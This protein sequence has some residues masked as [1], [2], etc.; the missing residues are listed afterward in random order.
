MTPV[1]KP[2]ERPGRSVETEPHQGA[3]LYCKPGP[4]W[5]DQPKSVAA[6]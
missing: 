4:V 3:A 2:R 1:L 5:R 6:M